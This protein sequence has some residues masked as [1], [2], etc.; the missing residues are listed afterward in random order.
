MDP[1]WFWSTGFGCKR[2]KM[3]DKKRKKLRNILFSSARCSLLRAKG[4]SC[5]LYVL[6]GGLGINKLQFLI[7]SLASNCT[8]L[9]HQNCSELNPCTVPYNKQHRTRGRPATELRRTWVSCR[10]RTW[11]VGAPRPQC[12]P[13]SAGGAPHLAVAPF[14]SR[15]PPAGMDQCSKGLTF[16]SGGYKEMSSIFADQ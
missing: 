14:P 1:H 11:W 5:S 15:S 7:K 8:I 16:F 2:E 13:R 10:Y 3:T 12:R 9:G 4:F 6:H